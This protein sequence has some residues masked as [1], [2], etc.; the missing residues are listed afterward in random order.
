MKKSSLKHIAYHAIREK[1]ISCEFA[2]NS[3]VNEA[4]LQ[5]KTNISRTP[6]REA[7]GILEQEGLLRIFPKKG[8]QISDVS[9]NEINQL[10]ETRSLV[11]PFIIKN[12]GDHIQF[13]E[14]IRLRDTADEHMNV[15]ESAYQ[16]DD[17]LH[18]TVAKSCF[19]T[20]LLR[21]LE[22]TKT[23][24]LRLRVLTGRIASRLDYSKGEHIAIIDK[25]LLK[26]FDQAAELMYYHLQ[27]SK[28]A[29]FSRLIAGN[30]SD[31]KIAF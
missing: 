18:S 15:P 14:L 8:I 21:T 11:E 10:F 31:G 6:I 16:W 29:S 26:E 20:Y 22:Q 1:I 5:E 12:Y 13:Q 9:I 19:N 3:F 25:L 17:E 7:L 4:F 30:G 2:P 27:Q 23:Q 28:N 24:S